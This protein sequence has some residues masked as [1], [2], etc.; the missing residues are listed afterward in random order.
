MVAWIWTLIALFV[1][2]VFGV[3]L[4]AFLEVAREDKEEGRR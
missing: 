2:I 3:S 1:G 4:F